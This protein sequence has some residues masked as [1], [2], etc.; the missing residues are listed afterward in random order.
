MADFD[1]GK[2]SG[3]LRTIGEVG[4]ALG[5]KPHV[6]RYWEQQFPML[7]PLKR[8][9]GRRYYRAED[10]ALVERIDRLVNREGYTLKGAKAAILGAPDQQAAAQ[11]SPPQPVSEDVV[12]QL[13]AIRDRLERALAA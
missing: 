3:A 11:D 7:E 5:I 1:D 4:Q 10:V 8:S 13:K 12:K 9:G 6:L 2:E